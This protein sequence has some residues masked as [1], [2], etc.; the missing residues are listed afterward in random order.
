VVR[1]QHNGRAVI[2]RSGKTIER[3]FSKRQIKFKANKRLIIL[4]Q[5]PKNNNLSKC[6]ACVQFEYR[7]K[8]RGA[9]E[10]TNE[11]RMMVIYK[12]NLITIDI[13][14]LILSNHLYNTNAN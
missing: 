11:G 7:P 8:K 10:G 4:Y 1:R 2:R 3:K 12:V 6:G 13:S 9:T 5:G 14:T